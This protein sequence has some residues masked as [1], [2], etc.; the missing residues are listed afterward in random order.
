[1]D[2]ESL[3]IAPT[4]GSEPGTI[5][6]DRLERLLALDEA[7]QRLAEHD[8]RLAEVVRLRFYAGLSNGEAALVLGVS[9]RTVKSDWTFAKAWLGRQ[10][11]G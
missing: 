10:A 7:V 11:P 4:E 9:E 1:M 6:Y 2:A 5:A 3:S 8:G